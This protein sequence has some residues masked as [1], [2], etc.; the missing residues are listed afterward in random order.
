VPKIKGCPLDCGLCPDHAQRTCTAVLEVTQRCNF[1]CAFCFAGSGP[2]SPVPDPGLDDIASL[3]ARVHEVSPGCNLQISG[4]EPTLRSDLVEIIA[5]AKKTGF[6]FIQ[7]NTNG[8]LPA[9]DPTLLKNLKQAGLSS[10]FLQFDGTSDRTYLQLRGLPLADIKK[11]AV[12]CCIE[13]GIGVI[14]VPTLVRGINMNEV[15]SILQF[16]LDHAPGIRG[17]HFQPVSYFGR[18]PEPAGPMD[19]I[20]IPEILSEM[21]SQTQHRIRRGD[22]RPS[23]CEHAMCSFNGKFMIM[24][25]GSV[26]PLMIFDGACCNPVPAEQGSSLARASVARQWTAPPEMPEPGARKNEPDGFDRF[27]ERARTHIFS[28]TGMAFQDVWNVDLERLK[29]CCIH[30]VS[31]DGRLI[32]FC[33]YNLTAVNGKG[34]YR[35]S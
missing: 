10:V 2:E 18:H 20:T 7:L 9:K 21:E 29:G 3:L 16:A 26:K 27:L 31:P 17:V 33:A 1:H 25:D 23:A 32:P 5:C 13:N 24:E 34:L 19:H 22:F 30:S 12:S 15:G 8:Y 6:E 4:G 28:V 11:K 35:T 14:L